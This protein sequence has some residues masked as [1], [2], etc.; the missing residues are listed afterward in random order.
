MRQTVLFLSVGTLAVHT[1]G[2]TDSHKK[3]HADIGQYDY[4]DTRTLVR[5]LMSA[6]KLLQIKGAGAFEGF[7][8]DKRWRFKDAYF[9]AYTTTGKCVCHGGMPELEGQE[10]INLQDAIGR[11]TLCMALQAARDPA[12]PH[13]WVHYWW[14]LPNR[15]Y[16]IWKSSC[17]TLVELPDKQVV[18]LGIGMANLPREKRFIK[19]IVDGASCLLAEKGS[20][21][22]AELR[23]PQSRF[24]LPGAMPTP[25]CNHLKLA[26]RPFADC[27]KYD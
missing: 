18:L 3:Q 15:L 21:A 12:N 13:G 8:Q 9:Y 25:L 27:I 24:N 14:N 26:S 1:F 7:R 6:K 23:N 11:K 5:L 22:L 2:C 16:P 20:S 10:L 19:I 4:Q 17:H